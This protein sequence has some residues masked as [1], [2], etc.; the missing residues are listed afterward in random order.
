VIAVEYFAGAGGFS[1]GAQAAGVRVAAACNHWKRATESYAANHPGTKV[2]CQDAHLVDPAALPDFSLFLNAPSCQGHS[3]ARGADQPRHDAARATAWCVVDVCELRRPA[4]SI[5]ENVPA[6]LKWK[7]WPM[8]KGSMEALGY[9]ITV[10]HLNAADFGVAQSRPRVFI[11]AKRGR[12]APVVVP[13]VGMGY[14]PRTARDVVSLDA[15]TWSRVKDKVEST[16]ARVA[17]GRREF[18]RAPFLISYY[19]SSKGGHSL[20]EPI[21]TI[22]THDRYAIVRGNEIR[23]LSVDELREFMGFPPGYVLCG[24]QKEQVMQL[25]N[26]VVPAVARYVV[27]HVLGNRAVADAA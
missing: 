16:Q 17:A 21:G 26:A 7:L 14:Q 3:N 22:T 4:I 20:D 5:T 27:S 19:G 25:G 2:I 11:V 12:R 24:N 13:P 23:M 15:G 18:G 8:W 9:S 1:T 10:N 6:F